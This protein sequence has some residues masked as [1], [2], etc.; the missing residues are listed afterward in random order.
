M[1]CT[2]CKYSIGHTL[3]A[4]VINMIPGYLVISSNFL[5]HVEMICFG[6]IIFYSSTL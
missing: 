6:K 1:E 2:L 4:L 5:G 3:K